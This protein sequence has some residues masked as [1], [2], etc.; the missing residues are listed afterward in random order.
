M[1]GS[2]HGDCAFSVN[3]ANFADRDTAVQRACDVQ[4]NLCSNAAN[5]GELQGVSVQDCGAQADACVAE[6]S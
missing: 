2:G 4:N 6:L 3:G 1:T 5:G